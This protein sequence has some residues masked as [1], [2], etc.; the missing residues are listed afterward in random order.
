VTA[1]GV[2]GFHNGLIIG[3]R[4]FYF[5]ALSSD[6]VTALRSSLAAALGDPTRGEFGWAGFGVSFEDDETTF[7]GWETYEVDASESVAA[8][9]P[10]PCVETGDTCR[11]QIGLGSTVGDVIAAVEAYR[12]EVGL[13]QWSWVSVD[14]DLASI[15]LRAGNPEFGFICFRATGAFAEPGSDQPGLADWVIAIDAGTRCDA[16]VAVEAS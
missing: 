6:E 11:D 1:D 8:R 16:G 14:G 15:A 13:D 10:I 5:G 4:E 7:S 3:G 9:L 2:I 12:T